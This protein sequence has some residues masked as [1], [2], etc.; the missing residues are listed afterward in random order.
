MTQ[1]LLCC[2]IVHVY[3]HGQLENALISKFGWISYSIFL[4]G[5]QVGTY[6]RCGARFWIYAAMFNQAIGA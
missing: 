5:R 6:I 3:N 4:S 1:I 2:I